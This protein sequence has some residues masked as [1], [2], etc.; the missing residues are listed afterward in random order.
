MFSLRKREAALPGFL[1]NCYRTAASL[2][3]TIPN[4]KRM[5]QAADSTIQRKTGLA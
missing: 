4:Y 3:S 2:L 1:G 5:R